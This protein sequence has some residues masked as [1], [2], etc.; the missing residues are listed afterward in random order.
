MPRAKCKETDSA[1]HKKK[2]LF[3]NIYF[4]STV[5]QHG[6]LWMIH[7]FQMALLFFMQIGH[8]SEFDGTPLP[9]FSV[10]II[11]AYVSC[12]L[13][14]IGVTEPPFPTDWN[15]TRTGGTV[16]NFFL[17]ERTN[18]LQDLAMT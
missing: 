1:V 10:L 12:F 16:P 9:E 6:A 17:S 4:F 14:D 13:E 15:W 8:C 3:F 7:N 18:T 11:S 5:L 2:Q